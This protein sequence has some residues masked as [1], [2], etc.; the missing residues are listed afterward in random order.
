[1]KIKLNKGQIEDVRREL[2]ETDRKD[3]D[4]GDI[5]QVFRM[6]QYWAQCVGAGEA[7]IKSVTELSDGY[8]CRVNEKFH[9]LMKAY[10]KDVRSRR[11]NEE[12]KERK[13]QSVVD[14]YDRLIREAEEKKNRP[15]EME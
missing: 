3:F 9:D 7:K 10:L 1:M 6:L 14:K 11:F 15:K 2:K 8:L 5:P 13:T 4:I 12:M